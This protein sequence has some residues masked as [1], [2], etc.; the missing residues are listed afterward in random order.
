MVPG[1]P[2]IGGEDGE[3][4]GIIDAGREGFTVE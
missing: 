3:A 4:F 1:R 2:W